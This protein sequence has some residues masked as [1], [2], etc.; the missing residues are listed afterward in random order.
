M[1]ARHDL[2]FILLVDLFLS[3]GSY[4]CSIDIFNLDNHFNLGTFRGDNSFI[5]SVHL[6]KN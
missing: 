2:W 5:A 1:E 6:N 3:V 4:D